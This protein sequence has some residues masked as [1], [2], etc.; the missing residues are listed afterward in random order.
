[1]THEAIQ[2]QPHMTPLEELE[3]AAFSER[4]DLHLSNNSIYKQATTREDKI[5]TIT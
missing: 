2:D 4:L 1:M 3:N 5:W